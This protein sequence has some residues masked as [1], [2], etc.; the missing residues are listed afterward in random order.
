[1]LSPSDSP[2]AQVSQHPIWHQQGWFW[3]YLLQQNVSASQ[4]KPEFDPREH[5]LGDSSGGKGGGLL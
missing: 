5:G 4:G 2:L 3:A 1:M